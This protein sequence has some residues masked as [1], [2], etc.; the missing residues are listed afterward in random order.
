MVAE[1]AR[2]EPPAAERLGRF[3]LVLV[4]S[5][6]QMRRAMHDLADLARRDVAHRVVDHARLDVEHGAA[7]RSGLADLIF[8]PEHGGERGDL[9]LPVEFHSRTFGIRRAIS[10]ITSTGMIEAP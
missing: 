5:E 8:R 10:R 3:L 7:R 9:R 2:V 1:I 4:I 6:H